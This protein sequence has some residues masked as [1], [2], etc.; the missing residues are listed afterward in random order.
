MLDAGIVPRLLAA[1][2]HS[3]LSS[4]PGSPA[5]LVECTACLAALVHG[6]PTLVLDAVVAAG[7]AAT[8]ARLVTHPGRVVRHAALSAVVDLSSSQAHTRALV[9]ASIFSALRLTLVCT[10]DRVLRLDALRTVANVLAARSAEVAAACSAARL[11]PSLVRLLG[12]VEDLEVQH[13]A[14]Y[15]V[16]SATVHGCEASTASLV[17]HGCILPLCALL[18]MPQRWSDHGPIGSFIFREECGDDD[19]RFHRAVQAATLSTALAALENIILAGSAAHLTTNVH[20]EAV[21]SARGPVRLARL[22]RRHRS[23]TVRD[24]AARLFATYF[25]SKCCFSAV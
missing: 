3:T 2:R 10:R 1:L 17:E 21:I 25:P 9:D 18:I 5:L 19:E 16:A 11:F 24:A 22:A 4:A 8:L 23:A 15:A 7:G 14:V 12:S 20:V 13:L 6:A